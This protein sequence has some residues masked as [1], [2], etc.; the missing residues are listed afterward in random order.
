MADA[1]WTPRRHEVRT[2]A[3]LAAPGRFLGYAAGLARLAGDDPLLAA[4]CARAQ[5][6]PE[7]F[8]AAMAEFVL[9]LADTA[10]HALPRP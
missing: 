2:A 3:A 5:W 8:L 10:D 1:D 7:Q 6:E 4:V 9:I